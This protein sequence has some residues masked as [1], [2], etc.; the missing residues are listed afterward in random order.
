MKESLYQSFRLNF[1]YLGYLINNAED[2][3]YKGQ[4]LF[5]VIDYVD[6]ARV[7][8]YGVKPSFPVYE[9]PLV[10]GRLELQIEF[11]LIFPFRRVSDHESKKTRPRR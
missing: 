3:F 5:L 7:N 9:H 6:Y 4:S 10:D 2:A 8:S 1:Q 11:K